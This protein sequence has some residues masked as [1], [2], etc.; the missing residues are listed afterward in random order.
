MLCPPVVP[1][2]MRFPTNPTAA[3]FFP[4]PST[5]GWAEAPFEN[6]CRALPL[7]FGFTVAVVL[8]MI[9]GTADGRGFWPNAGIAA[10]TGLLLAALVHC[11]GAPPAQKTVSAC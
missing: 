9:L 3:S 11:A 7:L 6:A 4:L 1:C 2:C 10:G 5:K 8:L